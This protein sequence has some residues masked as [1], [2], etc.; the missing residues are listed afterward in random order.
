MTGG[1]RKGRSVD[2][3]K[4]ETEV[5]GSMPQVFC[6]SAGNDIEVLDLEDRGRRYAGSLLGFL[7][8][9]VPSGVGERWLGGDDLWNP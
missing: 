3:Q 9:L 8:C 2:P 1:I 6:S 7:A 4:I 5:Q